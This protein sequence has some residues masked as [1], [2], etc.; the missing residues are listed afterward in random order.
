MQVD[1]SKTTFYKGM[2][3]AYGKIPVALEVYPEVL[4]QNGRTALK[5]ELF[6][7]ND[8]M[9]LV[10]DISR[11]L[12]SF[13]NRQPYHFSK[14]FIFEPEKM[15][16]EKADR[17]L[18]GFLC[19][20]KMR[21]EY[22]HAPK[23]ELRANEIIFDE[24]EGERLLDLLFGDMNS[25][26]LR[27]QPDPV[28]FENDIQLEIKV[29]KNAS[30]CLLT[31]DYS[32]YG[33]FEPLSINF[34]YIYVKS[35]RLIV[36]L[37]E[38]KQEF[39]MNLHQFQNDEN[40]VS[41]K[42]AANEMRL[43]QRNFLDSYGD[44]LGI[45]VDK[46]VMEA[47]NANR[48]LIKVYFDVAAGGIVSKIE[49]CYQEK[50]YN[51]LSDTGAD[52]SFR[53]IDRE[54]K[55][56]GKLK[57][58]GFR[59][60]GRLF[61]LDDIEKIMFLLTDRLKELKKLAEIYYSVDFK[62]L[63][64]K[65]LDDFDFG[66]SLSEDGSIIHM[67]INLE[68]VTDEELAELLEA[69]KRG[70]KYY[71]LKSGS[72]IN[73]GSVESS[74]LVGL[75]NSLDIQKGDVDGS[76][77]KIPL[78]RCMYIEHYLKEKKVENVKI[79]TR[80]GYVMKN[81]LCPSEMEVKLPACLKEVM[82]NYQVTGVKW[83]QTMA[84]YSFGGILAD[85]MGLG[86][87]LQVL[88][89]IA[90]EKERGEK[91]AGVPCIVVA[92]TSVIYNWKSEAKK[93]TPELKVAVITGIKDNRNL[94]IN[95]YKDY[96]LI[97]TSY[98]LLKNDIENY[99][100]KE[101]L[102][103]FLDEAQNIKNPETLNANSVKSLSARCAFA[104]TGT[105]IENR[106]TELWSIFDFIMPGLLPERMK[107]KRAYEEP[108]IKD[109]NPEKMAELSGMIKPFII[110]R[111]KREVLSE[112]PE[113]IE[114]NC[115]TEMK[116][117]QKKLYAA[118]YK[119]FKRELIP[120][121]EQS[122]MAGNHIEVLSALT[123]LRQ[124]CAHPG[125]FLDDYTG[126][127]SKLDLAM[128][129]IERSIGSGHSVLLFSQFTKMLQII[130]GELERNNINYYYLD[131]KM[132][133]EDRMIEVDNFN[134]DKESVFLVSLKAGGTGLNLTK[135]D[136]VIHFDPWWNPAVETQASDR[137]HR[138]GQ[139]NVV[140]VYNLMTEGTIEEMMARLKARKKDLLEGLIRP[141]ENFLGG[142][143]ENEIKDLLNRPGIE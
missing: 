128:D 56:L 30:S 21:R 132:K 141:G 96:D 33:H 98:G 45:S 87:T 76:M 77:F 48:L 66:L 10:N 100:K 72:I 82:R 119:D 101:F 111:L 120:K 143:S 130:S 51:P 43:F 70:K 109:R 84:S 126:G 136:V 8:R 122:G 9:Y 107:F 5:I 73:L 95:R 7:G 127:S 142:L 92:P 78:S 129:I 58:L 86:K 69:I 25:I 23:Q 68:N 22:S 59:E 103:I 15:Y 102:Y 104:L 52:K 138:F 79:D 118:F 91:K 124:I 134:Y 41:F 39:M 54:N 38:E 12:E 71:R 121:L 94:L 29:E 83:L 24:T 105:P 125:T 139:K 123:R 67:N 55:A 110:R 135:A 133:S 131:G 28:C 137:A 114:T 140:Q 75:I 31:A 2:N 113:K 81:I 63:H 35:K 74:Q 64:V 99:Q 27:K 18:L 47:M 13:K 44:K 61:L 19:G 16:F 117:G 93:F 20:V 49:F 17:R 4:G 32:E 112:L 3:A 53:E 106:L 11:F 85:D 65:N 50:I 37:P 40:K 88:A 14:N 26:K 89:F 34:R 36:K 90:S 108:I 1:F 116:A 6:A 46:K 42:I 62:K 115:L 60:Y 97:V 57:S 80:L